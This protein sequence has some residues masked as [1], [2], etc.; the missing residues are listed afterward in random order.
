MRKFHRHIQKASLY[1][2]ISSTVGICGTVGSYVVDR[3]GGMSCVIQSILFLLLLAAC[4]LLFIGTDYVDRLER[5]NYWYR[6]QL[7]ATKKSA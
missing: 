3:L 4:I 1:L 5:K 6:K 7:N 2:A